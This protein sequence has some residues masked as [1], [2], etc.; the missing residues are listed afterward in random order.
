MAALQLLQLPSTSSPSSLPSSQFYY[1]PST[2]NFTYTQK[3]RK[4][5]GL[6]VTFSDKEDSVSI[7]QETQQIQ[8]KEYTPDEQD[9]KDVQDIQRVID[10]LKKN[11]DMFFNEVKLTIMIEDPREVERRRLLGIDDPDTPTRDELAAALD[12]VKEGKVPEN[13]FALQVLAEE[14]RNW[15]NLEVEIKKSKPRKSLY[16]K[17]TDTGVDPQV[18]AKRLNIDWDTAAEID[19][20]DIIDKQDVP[21]IVG[22][23]A[24]YLVT[25]L[26]VII[27]VSVVLILFYNSL[28]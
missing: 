7:A 2:L 4:I 16:A 23:G 1:K 18:A 27:G 13:R 14:M 15:P 25:A 9:L 3:Q 10:L 8:E 17:A 24:L 12:D 5:R 19:D 20:A 11:R 26:P 28:Q 22:F 21:S 6:F